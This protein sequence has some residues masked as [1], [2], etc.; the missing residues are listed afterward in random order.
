ME[1]TA[2]NKPS[3]RRLSPRLKPR[4]YVKVECR[5]GSYGL[6]PN[7]ATAILDVSDTGIR[8]IVKKALTLPGEVEVTIG[9]YGLVNPIKRRAQI[10]W[11][12][13]LEDGGFCVGVEFGKR[14]VYRD[15][16]NLVSPR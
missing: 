2:S 16:Q 9:G 8:M 4:G 5:N 7:L 15:W 10:R 13:T 6:G 12:V 11:Q 3:N 1:K 14:L